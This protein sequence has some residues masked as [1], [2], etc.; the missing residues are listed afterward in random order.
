MIRLTLPFPPSVNRYWRH[1]GRRTLISREGRQFRERVCSD[2][3]GRQLKPLIGDLAVALD[4]HPPDRRRRDADNFF[5][6]ALDALEHAG[7]YENDSQITHLEIDKRDPV[8]GGR[9]IVRIE[10]HAEYLKRRSE[11]V[12][13][14]CCAGCGRETFRGIDDA[15]DAYCER[16][17]SHGSTHAFP[18][19]LDRRPLGEPEWFG[20]HLRY[21]LDHPDYDDVEDDWD[22]E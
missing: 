12:Q 18:E 1:V 10:P 6:A 9:T 3:A 14:V 5:K 13:P 21:D 7:V 8:R 2:L 11:L 22:D 17:I 15:A 19:D 4:L 20:G 16:C